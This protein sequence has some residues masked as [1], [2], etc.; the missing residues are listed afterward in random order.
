[1]PLIVGDA[2]CWWAS[3]WTQGS[4]ES[5]PLRISSFFPWHPGCHLRAVTAHGNNKP[6]DGQPSNGPQHLRQNQWLQ[7]TSHNGTVQHVWWNHSGCLMLNVEANNQ[8]L[9]AIML[10]YHACLTIEKAVITTIEFA[11][12]SP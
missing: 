8:K 3:R 5:L 4:R 9:T 6:S 1:M 11:K 7:Q 2:P 10:H 12:T